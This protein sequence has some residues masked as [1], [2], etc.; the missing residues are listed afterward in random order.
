M[1]VGWIETF[2][3]DLTDDQKRLCEW[4]A[5]QAQA[6]KTQI[7]Y[8]DALAE[9]PIETEDELTCMLRTL[10]ERVD[11]IHELVHSPI[12]NTRAPYFEIHSEADCIWQR[13][14]EAEEPLVYSEPDA[15][16]LRE[17]LVHC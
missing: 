10:R 13:Y 2:E 17:T 15:F 8:A 7:L 6:G 5:E 3:C 9:L 14:L 12:V 4:I 16:S 11:R 1:K